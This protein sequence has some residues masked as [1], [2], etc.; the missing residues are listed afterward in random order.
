MQ[1]TISLTALAL[2][3]GELNTTTPWRAYSS[4]GMLL[5]PA[6]QRA[7]ARMPAGRVTPCR[8]VERMRMAS[9]SSMSSTKS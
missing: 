9:A 5:T 4:T 8:S 3:P 6:P 1:M 2:A 7:M